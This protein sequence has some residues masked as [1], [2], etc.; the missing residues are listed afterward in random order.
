LQILHKI[1]HKSPANGLFFRVTGEGNASKR[2]QAAVIL[3]ETT[4]SCQFVIFRYISTKLD[5]EASVYL[6]L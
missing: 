2:R 3:V 6:L 5:G 4:W 1:L